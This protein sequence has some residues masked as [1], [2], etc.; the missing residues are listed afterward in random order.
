[1]C[2]ASLQL[3]LGPL[4][5]HRPACARCGSRRSPRV[6]AA[7]AQPRRWRHREVGH[8][9]RVPAERVGQIADRGSSR[10]RPGCRGRAHPCPARRPGTPRPRR[11][12]ARAGSACRVRGSRLEDR[13]VREEGADR[14]RHGVAEADVRVSSI[15]VRAAWAG[16]DARAEGVGDR[17]RRAQQ[18]PGPARPRPRPSGAGRGAPASH[19]RCRRSA[20]RGSRRGSR[21]RPRS[22]V[23]D[24]LA[25]PPW[26]T[27]RRSSSRPRS[28]RASASLAS[29][30]TNARWMTTS[31]PFTQQSRTLFT[32]VTSALAVLG[33]LPA[34]GRPGRTGAA[35]CPPHASPA[36]AL[37]RIHHGD[38]EISGRAG[39]WRRSGP[40]W[41]LRLSRFGDRLLDFRTSRAGRTGR[42]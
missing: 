6:A 12:R 24:P 29:R 41:P 40:R 32:S 39:D 30:I 23:G 35:P 4:G 21:R 15:I 13:H 22:S 31:A 3:L 20:S 14:R 18:A 28:A 26:P 19:V 8:R 7:A 34:P 25:R 33:L 38:A 42:P 10:G 37:E 16:H 36:R 11:P 2:L 1:M 5:L 9:H 27:P 17:L